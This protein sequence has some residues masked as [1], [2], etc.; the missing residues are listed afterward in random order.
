MKQHKFKQKAWTVRQAV[1]WVSDVFPAP[2]W[3]TLP[4][5]TQRLLEKSLLLWCWLRS[6]PWGRWAQPI[7]WT[8]LSRG[9]ERLES[10]GSRETKT[11]SAWWGTGP[12]SAPQARGLWCPGWTRG[13]RGAA[14][15]GSSPARQ[16]RCFC[17]AALFVSL[18]PPAA[19]PSCPCPSRARTRLRRP[20]R[21]WETGL[22]TVGA[23]FCRFDPLCHNHCPLKTID[24]TAKWQA[25]AL[26]HS[27]SFSS[28]IN[29]NKTQITEFTLNAS[30]PFQQWCHVGTAQW[31]CNTITTNQQHPLWIY[32]CVKG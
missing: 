30:V 25:E 32:M 22:W 24:N 10:P 27:S 8:S 26:L 1:L 17:P 28:P 23:R 2:R 11:G 4:E 19:Q 31:R 9:T 14:A 20:S 21:K 6:L 29:K 3:S 18:R 7:V 15:A 13:P 12:G 16:T 5:E